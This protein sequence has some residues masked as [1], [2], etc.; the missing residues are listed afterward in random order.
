M[1][2]SEGFPSG[3]VGKQA[4]TCFLTKLV[5]QPESIS[6]CYCRL[7]FHFAGSEISSTVAAPPVLGFDSLHWSDSGVVPP[8]KS[9]SRIH[10]VREGDSVGVIPQAGVD[11]C[12]PLLSEH[13]LLGSVPRRSVQ[14]LH[15]PVLLNLPLWC[16]VLAC[17][18]AVTLVLSF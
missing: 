11:T 14:R 15:T 4:D 3:C 12:D 8:P 16:L 5:V 17:F 2:V 13:R 18:F 1:A 6:N 10:W 7:T 9:V